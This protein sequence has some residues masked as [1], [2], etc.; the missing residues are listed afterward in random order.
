MAGPEERS[1]DLKFLAA[2]HAHTDC[3]LRV[4]HRHFD[5]EAA[6]LQFRDALKSRLLP[7]LEGVWQFR[8]TWDHAFD[9]IVITRAEP[10]TDHSFGHAGV[11]LSP[12]QK[13]LTFSLGCGVLVGLTSRL[14]VEIALLTRNAVTGEEE[15]IDITFFRTSL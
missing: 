7:L 10:N 9:G 12:T 4:N 3:H 6:R 1:R 15:Q 5:R 13:R 11:S 8:M 14:I 2:S